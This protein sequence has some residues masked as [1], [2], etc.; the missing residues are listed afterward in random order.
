SHKEKRSSYAPKTGV[1]YDGIY[2]LEKC[3]RKIGIPV[4]D[5]YRDFPR[6]LPLIKELKKA[7]DITNRKDTPSWV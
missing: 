3:W 1:R 5:E 7:T 6:P 4:C 2:M